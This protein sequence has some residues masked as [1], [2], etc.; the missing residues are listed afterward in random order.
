TARLGQ[1]PASGWRLLAGAAVGAAYSLA[2]LLPG[3]DWERVVALKVLFSIIMVLV[4][5]YPLT[6]RRFV[7]ALSY[8]YMVA[9]AMGG[10]MLG[11]IYL[12]GG[13]V[14]APVGGGAAAPA[15]GI[16][17]TWLLVAAGAAGL[18][19]FFGAG[20]I[21]KNFWQQVLRLPVVIT[22]AGRQRALKALVDTGNSLRDP[23]SRRPVIIVEYSAL[24]DILP[25]EIKEYYSGQEE[26]P[27]LESL[28][29][30]LASS[31]WVKRLHL[32]PY[33]SLGRSHG[34]L[35]GFRPDEV[36][37]I[38]SERM[39]KIKDVIVGLYGERLSPEG[40]YRA[41]LHPDLLQLSMGL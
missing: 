25:A 15:P 38:T 10:A 29:N 1:L 12:A 21:K 22:I 23:L 31:P 35:L 14:V 8:F 33:H 34:M 6:G 18:L 20:W 40:A 36:I 7:Q 24:L 16:R 41:L 17:F 32:L 11:V 26:L 39:I 4:A 9:F 5:F 27:D 30:S 3:N 37:V 28:V 2:I 13:E 19:A